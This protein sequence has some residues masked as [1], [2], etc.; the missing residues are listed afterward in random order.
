MSDDWFK[1]SYSGS[2]PNCVECRGQAGVTEM[3]DSKN[4][5][6]ATLALPADQWAGLLATVRADQL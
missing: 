3:R 6:H 1:S 2:S 4:P 5:A